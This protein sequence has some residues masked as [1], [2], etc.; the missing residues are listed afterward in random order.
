MVVFIIWIVFIPLEQ[1]A[2]WSRIKKYKD[3]SNIIMPSK[4]TGI[5]ELIQYKK[6]DKEPFFIYTDL[7]C[8]I[9]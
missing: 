4:D 2:K 9:K 8:I 3:F 5:L 6:S 7:E 1:K